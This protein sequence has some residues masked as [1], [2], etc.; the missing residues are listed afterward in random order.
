MTTE[1]SSTYQRKC[2][3]EDPRYN[4]DHTRK[5]F[6]YKNLHRGCWSIKQDGLV[7]M[8][9]TDLCMYDCSFRVNKKGREKVLKEKR[10]NVHA[11]IVGYIDDHWDIHPMGTLKSRKPKTKLAKYDPYKYDS[12]VQVD[13]DT[14]PVFWSSSVRMETPKERGDKD[15]VEYIPSIDSANILT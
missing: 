8:H 14:K 13:D 6:V 11:G 15:K 4:I 3:P 9:I 5:V 10:K 2:H 12:F 7:K 1:C